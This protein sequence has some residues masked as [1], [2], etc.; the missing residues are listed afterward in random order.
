M[1]WWTVHSKPGKGADDVVFIREGFNWWALLFP[2]PW[3]V[4]KGM[5]IILLIALGAQFAIWA[6]AEALGLSEAMRLILSLSINLILAFE[7]NTLLRWT[8]EQRGFDEL[9]LV[10]GDDLDEAEYR[11]FTEIGLPV[12][13][14]AQKPEAPKPLVFSSR[15][16]A[17]DP[18]FIFPGFGRK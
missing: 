12:T 13:A 11:F 16:K 3:L 17:E 7:G 18:D 10:H 6:A 4:I 5:W 9:G 2:L 15:W 8:C 1:A 14:E